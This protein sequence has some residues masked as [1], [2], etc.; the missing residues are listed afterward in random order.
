MCQ[1]LNVTFGALSL[2]C[3][4]GKS[5][6]ASSSPMCAASSVNTS[7]INAFGSRLAA[8]GSLL[9]EPSPSAGSSTVD[10]RLRLP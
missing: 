9:E 4:T 3:F 5:V 10:G 2:M 1:K 6:T 8:I 7:W